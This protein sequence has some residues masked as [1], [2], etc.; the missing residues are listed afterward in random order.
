MGG[1]SSSAAPGG[2]SGQ[3]TYPF[4]GVLFAPYLMSLA[5]A[6]RRAAAAVYRREFGLGQNE[7]RIIGVLGFEGALSNNEIAERIALDKGQL[8]REVTRLVERG[9]VVRQRVRRSS[10]I[11]LTEEGRAVYRRLMTIANRRNRRLLADFAE[12]DRDRLFALLRLIHG[13]AVE[14]Q[15][16]GNDIS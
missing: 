16:N 13:R 7:W 3:R 12:E 1:K 11:R 5:A 6:I 2:G 8:S 15:R 10:Q 14:M 4:D 9:L